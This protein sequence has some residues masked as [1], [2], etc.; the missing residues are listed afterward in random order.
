MRRRVLAIAV[1][2]ALVVPLLLSAGDRVLQPSDGN[3]AE[4]AASGTAE[5]EADADGTADRPSGNAT[6]TTTGPPASFTLVATGDVL[7]HSPL[8]RQ[9]EADG[10]ATG[11]GGMDFAPL[12]AGIRPTVEDADLAICHMETPIAPAGGPYSGYPSFSVPPEIVPALAATGYD[13]CTTG[14][15][16]TFDRGADGVDR[17]IAALEAGGLEHAGSARSPAEA[18]EITLLQAGEA[19]VALLSYSYAFNGIPA[20]NGEAWRANP[21]DEN[22]IVSDATGARH[23]GADV[24]VVALHWGLEYQNEPTDQQATLA[25][26]LIAWPDIDLLIGHHAH[27]VQPIQEVGGEWIVYGMGNS[28]ATQSSRGTGKEEGLIVRFTFTEGDEG[29]SVT[30]AEYAPTL[31]AEGFSPLRLVEVDRALAD[32]ATDPAQRA[33]LEQARDR[34]AG[35]VNSLGA[36]EAGLVPIQP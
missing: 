28:L 36:A 12:L 20:P 1:G 32:P 22:R 31:I 34:T 23:A 2:V 14:S 19:T 33:R 3:R 27:V 11:A 17:T 16:H 9:A 24:V 6:S 4:R 7:L 5:Q 25:P 18:T 13:A 26:R 29:W 30:R 15:N 10:A 8:W 21:I 35:I